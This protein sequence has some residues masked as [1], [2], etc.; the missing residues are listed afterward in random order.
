MHRFFI[1]QK[2]K[3][4]FLCSSLTCSVNYLTIKP[5]VRGCTAVAKLSH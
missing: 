5:V 3:V 4:V 2:K 1:L